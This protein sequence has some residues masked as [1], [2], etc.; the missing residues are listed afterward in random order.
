MSK[1]LLFIT[2]RIFWPTNSGRK[3]S[4][5][6]YCRGL[7]DKYNYNIYVYTFLEADQNFRKLENSK[8]YF[9]NSMYCSSKVGVV[10]KVKNLL[11]N[12]FFMN[13]WPLQCSLFY[14]KKNCDK[15]KD[16]IFKIQPEAIIVDMVRLAPYYSA[17]RDYDCKKILDMDDVLSKRYQRQINCKI[18]ESNFMG[19]YTESIGTLFKKIS[20]FKLVK[21]LVLKYESY[22][23]DRAERY[24]SEIY[25]KVVLVSQDETQYINDILS[26]DKAVTVSLGVDYNYFSAPIVVEKEKDSLSFVG[27]FYVSANADSL[28]LI[29]T[30][31]LPLLDRKVILYVIGT[32]PEQIKQKYKDYSNII[33]TG[34]V[35][36]LRSFVKRTEV[37]VSPIAYGSGIK[38]KILEAMAIGVPVVTNSIGAEGL[39]VVNGKQC[40][41]SDDYIEI[42][43]MINTLLKNED[44]CIKIGSCGQ[45]YV[46]EYH[47]W[48]KIFKAF[49]RIGL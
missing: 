9:I 37:F 19:V 14:S 44:Y 47:E 4:L 3:L 11:K 25:D 2:T 22:L 29:V 18:S 21:K 16:L 33:F 15:L 5:Y 17:F 8:P 36:D 34:M 46:N 41:I 35:D 39:G 23:M 45:R 40:L 1:N 12:S 48:N 27:N 38:T 26:C 28:Y 32:C 10:E 13:K 7:H 31:I 24:F 30:K 20:E 42:A 43:E 49:E 6:Q